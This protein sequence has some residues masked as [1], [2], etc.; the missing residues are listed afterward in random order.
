MAN[1]EMTRLLLFARRSL[2]VGGFLLLSSC[3]RQGAPTG[4]PKD[5][6][7]PRV[8]SL[9]S[10]PNYA[11]RFQEK[12]IELRFD[13][14]VTLSEV[15]TQVV[16]SPPLRTKR[17]PDISLKG[18]TVIVEIPENDTLRPNTTYTINFG[19][20][21]KDLHEGN[22]AKDLRF[23]FSTGDYIDS[24]N[25]AGIVI[26]AFKLEPVENVAVMLYDDLSDSVTIKSKPFYF[27]RTDKSGQFNIPNIRVGRFKAVAVDDK[28]QN[29]LW[30][31]G[32][33]RLA[34]LAEPLEL[35]DS[36]RI[37]PLALRLFQDQPLLRS[38]DRVSRNF[39]QV[40]ITYNGP[41]DTIA[42]RSDPPGLRLI[43]E[44]QGDTLLVWYD[45]RDSVAWRLLADRDTIQV[46]SATRAAFMKNHRCTWADDVAPSPETK[47]GRLRGRPTAAAPPVTGAK[48]VSQH[49]ARRATL[50]FNFPIETV[51]TTRW[52]IMQDSTPVTA[53]SVVPDSASPR[54]LTLRLDW[55]PEKFYLLTL[56]PGAVTDL[57][58]TSNADTLQRRFSILSEKQLGDLNLTLKDL[59]PGTPYFL[60]LLNGANVE[61]ERRFR[62]SAAEQRILFRQLPAATYTARLIEDRNGNG[63]WDAGR[64]FDR[65]QPEPLFQKALPPLRAN[66][67][68][69]ATM[70]ASENDSRKKGKAESGK[71]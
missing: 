31:G 20:A 68:V 47:S 27:A 9:T 32:D 43:P 24:L 63:R 48:T 4:G 61:E 70:P 2:S 40:K 29:L 21:I 26:D 17:V 62:A 53:F 66:W 60:Q 41:P 6:T 55:R 30:N 45:R 23:V 56:L 15:A 33:E 14:W 13:E 8:D 7:P 5:T 3:A 57:Y 19:N 49:P 36:A 25:V 12:K 51:D 67:E 11:T 42:L 46:K 50:P 1:D 52:S 65:R 38:K 34:F 37:K 28:D 35:G 64:Y 69:E 54:S 58:G 10:T 18:K 44:K 22:P 59:L 71:Q 39:G 16:V